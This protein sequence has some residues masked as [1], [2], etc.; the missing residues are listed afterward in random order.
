[1]LVLSAPCVGKRVRSGREGVEVSSSTRT[2]G[3][4][5]LGTSGS[6]MPVQDHTPCRGL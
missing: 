3:G 4:G 5:V 1:M 2:L 6:V